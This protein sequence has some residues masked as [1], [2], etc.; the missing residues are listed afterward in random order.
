MNYKKRII[1]P[2]LYDYYLYNYLY[3]LSK[4]LAENNFEVTFLTFDKK[5]RK[6]V[7]K[8]RGIN[9]KFAPKIILFLINR[10][11]N[12]FFRFFLWIFSYI[13][14]YKLKKIYD[15]IILPN[16]QKPYFYCMGLFIPSII[17]YV[18]TEFMNINYT[19]NYYKKKKPPRFLLFDK[20]MGYKP[21]GRLLGSAKNLIVPGHEFKKNYK[22]LCKQ[23]NLKNRN[24][25]V[26]G[27]PSYENVLKIKKNWSAQKRGVFLK[28][29]NINYKKNIYSFFLTYSKYDKNKI[30]EIFIVIN[31]IV[32][33]KK[34]C[35]FLLILHPKTNKDDIK[36]IKTYLSNFS[37]YKIIF[38]KG[39]EE[40]NTK[41][42]LSSYILLQKQSTVGFLIMLLKKPIISYNIL[43]T[44]YEDNMYEIMGNSYHCKT[45]LSLR[46]TLKFINNKKK[47]NLL[48]KKQEKSCYKFCYPF[49]SP[50][51]EIINIIN[52]ILI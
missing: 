43:D 38:G 19:L 15:L 7:S 35:F 23:S 21:K 40:F 33:Q 29:L 52:K 28:K 44:E 48:E 14:G 37:N 25:F 51:K 18:A 32:K 24:I 2:L 9:I 34:N 4:K 1:I 11:N 30:K 13:W 45:I 47:I 41:I 39:D 16:D 49:T 20:I 42:I 17:I 3:I 27:M 12:L 50:S 5:V 10:S 26:A 22:L 8:K 46:K 6:K 36:H 31:E